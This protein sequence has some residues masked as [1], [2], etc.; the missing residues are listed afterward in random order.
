MAKTFEEWWNVRF[1]KHERD[2]PFARAI[3]EAWNA[4]RA[5]E[6]PTGK[7][8]KVRVAVAVDKDGDWSAAGSSA[9]SGEESLSAAL[10]QIAL[11]EGYRTYWLEADLALPE[12]TVVVPSVRED[13][14]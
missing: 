2:T 7:T 4:A 9:N 12:P 10:Y 6:S 1:P 13:W 3:E 5:V 11:H 8:V 14:K